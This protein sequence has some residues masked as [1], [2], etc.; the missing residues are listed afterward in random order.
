MRKWLLL[1]LALAAG[2]MLAS[3]AKKEGKEKSAKKSAVNIYEVKEEELEE[4]IESN[5]KVDTFFI[6]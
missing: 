4:L 2:S 1:V 5:D 6:F 3:A